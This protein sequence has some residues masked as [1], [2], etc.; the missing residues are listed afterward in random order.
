M[1]SCW[2]PTVHP[3][4]SIHYALLKHGES[5]PIPFSPKFCTT[6]SDHALREYLL[7]YSVDQPWCSWKL[8]QPHPFRKAPA[9]IATSATPIKSTCP[10]W[11]T[12]QRGVSHSLYWAHYPP[13]QCHAPKKHFFP[14]CHHQVSGGCGLPQ[15]QGQWAPTASHIPLCHWTAS[16]SHTPSQLYL[17]LSVKEI[18]AMEKYIEETLKQRYIHPSTSPAF[19]GFFFMEK[20]GVVD[21]HATI[22]VYSKSQLSI[23]ILCP[24][25]SGSEAV[26][27]GQSLHKTW[28]IQCIQ[29][30]SYP[31]RGQVDDILQHHLWPLQ[32]LHNAI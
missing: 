23:V 13:F 16:G 30:G 24:G 3:W 19:T 28:P 22:A 4:V 26:M 17:P 9:V 12:Q 1:V 7:H 10:G 27:G 21:S 15:N 6:S 2:G 29:A 25:P 11:R 14:Y 18:Q 32:I 31:C 8:Y 5:T 20:E